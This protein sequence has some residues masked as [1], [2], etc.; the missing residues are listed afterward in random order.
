ME[1][2][3][4]QQK[5]ALFAYGEL[6]DDQCHALEGHLSDLQTVPGGVCSRTSAATGDGARAQRRSLPP[7][8]WRKRAYGWKKLWT[9]CRAA[10]GSCASSNPCSEAS[11]CSAGLRLRLLR[12]WFWAWLRGMGRLSIRRPHSPSASGIVCRHRGAGQDRQRQQHRPRTKHRKCRSPLQS[13]G[14]GDRPGIAG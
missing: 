10:A 13:A 4:A 6:P 11:A 5:I 8:C 14:S 3:L 2:E 12:C 7:I 9:T 1:C